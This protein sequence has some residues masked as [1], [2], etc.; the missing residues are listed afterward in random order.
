M[1]NRLIYFL[2]LAFITVDT[3][4]SY[5]QHASA[6]LDGDIAESVLPGDNFKPLFSSPM[7]FTAIANDVH[8][9]NPNRFFMHWPFQVYMMQMPIYLQ[10]FMDPISSVYTAAALAKTFIQLSLVFLLAMAITGTYNVLCLKFMLAAALLTP[11]FQTD[12]FR[13]LMG[14]IDPSITYTFPY[15]LPCL[16]MLIYFLPFIFRYYH[17]KPIAPNAILYPV[18]IALSVIVCLSGPL[19]PGIVLVFALIAFST[20][21]LHRFNLSEKKG[22]ATKFIAAFQDL[23]RFYWW[24]FTPVSL[25]AL[26]SLYLGQYNEHNQIWSISLSELYARL[27]T[28]IFHLLSEKI[29]Y[30]VL[31]ISIAINVIIIKK[32]NI[33]GGNKVISVLKW[34][35][36]FALIY[37]LLLPLGGYRPYRPLVLRYD[38]IMPIT[39]G[40]FFVFGGST[41]AILNHLKGKKQLLYLPIVFAVVLIYS[42]ADQAKLDKNAC[43]QLALQTIAESPESMVVLNS[44]CSVLSWF[45]ITDPSKSEQNARLIKAWR[46][47]DSKKLYYSKE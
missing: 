35:G 12:G 43:E 6:P 27:P 3:V 34:I 47:T 37:I 40:L 41:L 33:V 45:T 17:N 38:T 5:R 4:Y 44:S 25:L 18:L 36:L 32:L 21:F 9:P 26:Y 19:N 22:I 8:Y 1:V 20:A 2:L 30:P 31:L 29:A 13:G 14:I 28:G 46:I 23:P 11:L 42:F 39:L 16:F 15:A 7:G 10:R 24:Y